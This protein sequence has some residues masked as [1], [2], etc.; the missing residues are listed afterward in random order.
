MKEAMEMEQEEA[1]LQASSTGPRMVDQRGKPVLTPE[2][3]ARKS[4]RQKAFQE[5]KSAQ[6]KARV[7]KLTENLVNKV[8][9][10]AESAKNEHDRVVTASFK[11]IAKLEAA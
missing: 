5:K 6:R 9:I 3:V 11:E 4:A 10:F 8:S 7:E 1:A 2:E